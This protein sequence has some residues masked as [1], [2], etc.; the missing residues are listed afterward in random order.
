MSGPTPK[1]DI[2]QRNSRRHPYGGEPT[3]AINLM[4]ALRRSA[5]AEQSQPARKQQGKHG[6]KCIEGHREMLFL[7][8]GLGKKPAKEVARNPSAGR[9]KSAG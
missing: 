9:R 4:D 5:W 3:K 1:V 8:S 6:R 2:R 7:I